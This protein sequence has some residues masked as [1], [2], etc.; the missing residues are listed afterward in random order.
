MFQP[1]AEVSTGYTNDAAI[2]KSVEQSHPTSNEE[3][4]PYSN[5]NLKG[6]L[7]FTDFVDDES[8]DVSLAL[9]WLIIGSIPQDKD[10]LC[11]ETKT[12]LN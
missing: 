2:C 10:A 8:K 11:L 6:P 3:I 9:I 7:L 5:G 1:D 12:L 4:S